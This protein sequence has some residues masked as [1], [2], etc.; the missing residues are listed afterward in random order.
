MNKSVE[1]QVRRWGRA[2]GLG[3]VMVLRC[4]P[5]L[6]VLPNLEPMAWRSAEDAEFIRPPIAC[7]EQLDTL[8]PLLLRDL[9]SYANRVS[10][11][12][13]SREFR[14]TRNLPGTIIVAG[15]PE[16]EAI[17][18]TARQWP[19]QDN[20]TQQIFFTTL[21]RQYVSNAIVNLQQYHWL[22]LTRTAAGWQFVLLFS[23]IGDVPAN[24]P[25]TPPQDAS[26]GV[27]AQ[28]I[29]LWLRDCQAGRITAP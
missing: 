27:I 28:A 15:Q 23:A 12:A 24:E 19:Q 20:T 25:P 11:R 8:I 29:R 18:L 13:Y 16:Y 1:G 7:P 3:L 6:A 4:S 2:I 10:Q 9:P 14:I 17:E 21:E 26:Q 22:F 5:T